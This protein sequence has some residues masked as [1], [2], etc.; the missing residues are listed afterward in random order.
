MATNLLMFDKIRV[1]IVTHWTHI[2]SRTRDGA[3]T[4]AKVTVIITGPP[5]CPPAGSRRQESENIFLGVDKLF[6]RHKILNAFW[7]AREVGRRH[8]QAWTC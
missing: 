7:R 2:Y 4:K 1:D 3:N 6:A 8:D 5:Y